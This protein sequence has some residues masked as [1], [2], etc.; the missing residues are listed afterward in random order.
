MESELK[1][2]I[3]KSLVG[4]VGIVTLSGVGM[5]IVEARVKFESCVYGF[6]ETHTEQ[7]QKEKEFYDRTGLDINKMSFLD[8]YFYGKALEK[9]Y[10]SC[11]E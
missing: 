9:D 7:Q 4:L 5:D 10:I 1:K 2:T 8:K 11:E 6:A 3:I